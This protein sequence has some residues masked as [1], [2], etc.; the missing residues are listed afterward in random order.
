MVSHG[1]TSLLDDG[2][3][4]SWTLILEL[5]LLCE[6]I[7]MFDVALVCRSSTSPR[8]VVISHS[9]ELDSSRVLWMRWRRWPGI[10]WPDMQPLCAVPDV[11]MP[12]RPLIRNLDMLEMLEMLEMLKMLLTSIKSRSGLNASCSVHHEPTLP[13]A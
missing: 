7:F 8:N 11:C 9:C 4:L 6:S 5:E 13:S 12:E 2:F 10:A 3:G 1:K